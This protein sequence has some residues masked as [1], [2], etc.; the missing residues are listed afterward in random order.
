MSTVRK[1]WNGGS[2]EA[3][4]QYAK[5]R[6]DVMIS[7]GASLCDECAGEG[8]LQAS[9]ICQQC[10]GSGCIIPADGLRLPDKS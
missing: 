6:R 8:G 4:L 1:A 3:A 10:H 5:E 9:G 7:Q 2:I